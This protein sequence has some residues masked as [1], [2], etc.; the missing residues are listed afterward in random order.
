MHK[1]IHRRRTICIII[2]Y[3]IGTPILAKTSC[4]NPPW[5]A[6]A[7]HEAAEKSTYSLPIFVNWPCTRKVCSGENLK[8]PL[9]MMSAGPPRGIIRD[10]LCLA[11]PFDIYRDPTATGRPSFDVLALPF[12]HVSRE[13]VH[14]LGRVQLLEVPTLGVRPGLQSVW[15]RALG[16]VHIFGLALVTLAWWSATIRKTPVTS[17]ASSIC[18]RDMNSRYAATR[19]FM[20]SIVTL[21]PLPAFPLELCFESWDGGLGADVVALS[22]VFWASR[23]I[24]LAGESSGPT[25]RSRV[26]WFLPLWLFCDCFYWFSCGSWSC[27]RYC[28]AECRAGVEF[29]VAPRSVAEPRPSS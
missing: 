17:A 12:Q 28:S 15:Q 24:D 6:K 4:C 11:V 10:G 14:H 19:L 2:T 25:S 18:V 22:S 27:S 9:P 5:N 20:S 3:C 8:T 16:S 23:D 29:V 26:Y 13:R 1:T 7:T 21:W